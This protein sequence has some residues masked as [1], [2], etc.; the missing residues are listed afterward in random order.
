MLPFSNSFCVFL[1]SFL[2]TPVCIATDDRPA[3]QT[4]NDE[5]AKQ[6]FWMRVAIQALRDLNSPCSF[7][8]FGTAIVNHTSTHDDLVCIGANAI[9]STGNPTLHGEIAGIN[10][11]TAVL[12][13]PNGKYRLLPAEV[14]EA[15]KHLTLYTTAEPCPMCA[16]AIRWAGFH[17]CV[18]G[19]SIATLR[20][21]GWSQ[22]DFTSHELFAHT[23][24][25]KTTTNLVGGVLAD[26]TDGLFAWQFDELA[27]CPLGCER[28]AAGQTCTAAASDSDEYAKTEL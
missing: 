19:T 13:D 22:I 23:S 12:S 4:S 20:K 6:E 16:S 26:E 18:F 10:N 5:E 3:Q 17:E 27:Q 7:E 15:Y 25:L 21:F 11:C 8:A 14:S 1:L 2:L 28:D 9:S 24:G